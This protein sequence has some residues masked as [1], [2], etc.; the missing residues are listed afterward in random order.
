MSPG[1]TAAMDSCCA[2]LNPTTHL[3]NLGKT[4]SCNEENG[5]SFLNNCGWANK[6]GKKLSLEK[7]GRKIKTGVAYSVLT[8]EN[9]NETVVSYL[10]MFFVLEILNLVC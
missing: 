8:R 5:L 3:P 1:E 9:D 10:P 2:I 4:G 6:L 7:K